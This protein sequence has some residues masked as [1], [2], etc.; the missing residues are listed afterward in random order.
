MSRLDSHIRQKIAQ[1]DSINLAARWLASEPGVVVEFGLGSGR[2]Y[3][4]LT[5]R[6]A[7]HEVFCFDRRDATH[8]ASRPPA[9]H[10]Y[11]G[12]LATILAD[13][14]VHAR[15][16]AQVIL[17]H[18]DLGTGGPEDDVLPEF[19][20]GRIHAW[21]RARAVVLSDLDLT[22]DRAWRLE[23]VDTT[24]QVEHADR[25]FVYRRRDD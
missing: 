13:P 2:S 3:S 15:F 10:F 4:H 7:G 17:A 25:Y 14:T 23:R 8:P 9:D 16:T 20:I 18:L 5:E 19:V 1:R 12:E 24:G 22:L 11:R 21:L 6:F